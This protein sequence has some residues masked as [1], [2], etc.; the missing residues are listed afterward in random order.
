[1][2]EILPMEWRQVDL[3]G[4]EV[5]LDHG[6]TKNRAGR[7]F[8]LTVALQTL[9]EALWAEHKVLEKQGTICRYVFNRNGKQIKSLRGPGPWPARQPGIQG[10]FRTT[11]DAPRSGTWNGPACRGLWPCNSLGTRPRRSI[12]VTRSRPRRIFARAWR[13]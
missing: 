5:R 1:M 11:S 12:D 13:G 2:S 7:V 3:K 8:P 9:L 10:A 6:S 4:G